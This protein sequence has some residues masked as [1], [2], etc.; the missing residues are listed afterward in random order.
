MGRDPILPP[1]HRLLLAVYFLL[2]IQLVPGLVAQELTREQFITEFN[3]ALELR[4]EKLADKAMKRGALHALFYYDVLFHEKAGGAAAG[5]KLDALQATWKRCFDNG[6][7]MEKLHRWLDGADRTQF[8]AIE[9]SRVNSSRLWSFYQDTVAKDL[10]KIEH[11][12]VMQ[13]F[14]ELA[15]NVESMGHMLEIADIWGMASVIGSRMP[16]QSLEDKRDTVFA[17]KQFLEARERWGF[18]FDEHYIRSREW[19]NVETTRLEELEKTEEKRRAAGY[20]PNAKG[21]DTLVMPGVQE[22][23]P[24]SYEALT[25][26]ET[27]LDYGPKNG[28]VPVFWWM[29]SLEKEGS[30]RKLEW[31]QRVP[32]Y[33]V[34]SGAAKF[35]VTLDPA[36]PKKVMEIDVSTKGKPST[37]WLDPDKKQ[38]YS[39]FF[40]CG[41]DRERVG[42]CEC[43][44]QHS[45]EVA[46][47]YYRSAASWKATIGTEAVTFYDDSANGQ[48]GDASPLEPPLKSHTVGD[49]DGEGTVVP[50]LDSMRIGKGPRVPFSEFV[51]LAGGWKHVRRAT[52]DSVIVRPLNPEFVK[53][54]KVKLV[55][56]GP[57]PT[58][59]VQLVVGG[60]GDYQTAFFDLA[61]GKEVE[62]PAGSYSVLFGRIVVGKGARA[63][64]ATIYR[65]AAP[66]FTVEEGKTFEL[67]MGAPFSITFARR[68]DETAEINALKIMLSE[69]SGCVLTELHGMSVVPEVL[70]AKAE[71][72]KGAKVV[73]KF[74]RFADWE[75]VLKAS[76]KAVNLG[77]FVACF[78]MPD[79]YRE[80][81][82]VL[83]VKL[84][85]AGMKIGLA[86]KKHPLFG[87]LTSTFQ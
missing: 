29:A 67:K 13:Q 15:R 5:P 70:V 83:S 9:K 27:E 54:G 32:L 6:E 47:I 41:T 58:A 35:G 51:H 7:T 76:K 74:V 20:D 33:M 2:A 43:N 26:W 49:P 8:E 60:V 53:I 68:G 86:M 72:G 19:V 12:K 23:L 14:M 36:D 77:N 28:P 56:N 24:L 71:D 37:F 18:T 85:A 10:V 31:F 46:N 81:D 64:M 62:V 3:Q 87:P 16:E 61:S 78:P 73:G 57:K 79:G 65:G 55:W 39:M 30:N 1:M 82:M 22:S 17:T 34:R 80:G 84:P 44:L 4:D 38:P 69:A 52:P 25:T 66:A 50:L 48:P 40:W 42:E 59:P 45:D 11:K 21:I 75:L 63:Q